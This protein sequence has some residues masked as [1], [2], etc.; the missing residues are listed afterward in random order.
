MP[1]DDCLRVSLLERPE[2][3]PETRLLFGGTVVYALKDSL[4][5]DD[6]TDVSDVDAHGVEALDSIGYL[7]FGE[8]LMDDAICRDDIVVAWSLEASGFEHCKQVGNRRPLTPCGAVYSD[9]LDVSWIV[10]IDLIL[11]A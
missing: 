5:G 11:R 6:P 4:L 3:C 7:V 9:V 1:L 8:E 10:H 2:E